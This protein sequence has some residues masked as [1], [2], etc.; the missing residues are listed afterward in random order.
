MK[1]STALRKI[2][3]MEEVGL[4]ELSDRMGYAF[5]TA[6]QK[7]LTDANDM[8]ASMIVKVANELGYEV[9]IRKK[10]GSIEFP[11]DE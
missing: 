4:K 1:A 11:I 9:I 10:D 7:R 3:K 8:K 6:L 2:M 5:Y